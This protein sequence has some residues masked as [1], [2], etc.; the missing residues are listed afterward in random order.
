MR[1]WQPFH[2]SYIHLLCFAFFT[3]TNA[4]PSNEVAVADTLFHS[5]H[6]DIFGAPSF[7][8]S[9]PLTP[10]F[11]N[12]I[13]SN[14][15]FQAFQ[16]LGGGWNLYYS[17]WIGT[18]SPIQP[19]AW[20]LSQLY[21]SMVTNGGSI[22]RLL[23]PLHRIPLRVGNVDFLMECTDEPIPWD[24]VVLFGRRLLAI[25][26]G[27]WTGLYQLMLSNAENDVTVYVVLSVVDEGIRMVQGT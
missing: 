16:Y 18:S 2:P 26:N 23:Q 10:R 19:A 5:S 4:R 17:S 8:E 14:T 12:P 27:G 22:W 7:L 24:L 21:S 25:T 20:A 15:G 11:S 1:C 13:S 3:Q 9:N 6:H